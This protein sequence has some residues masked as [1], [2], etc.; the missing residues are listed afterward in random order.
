MLFVCICI[1]CS[2]R[3]FPRRTSQ[4]HFKTGAP[5]MDVQTFLWISSWRCKSAFQ[6]SCRFSYFSY[7]VVW[8]SCPVTLK[9]SHKGSPQARTCCSFGDFALFSLLCFLSLSGTLFIW[10]LHLIA[11]KNE[12]CFLKNQLLFAHTGK[13]R[14]I[15][16]RHAF[17]VANISY[18]CCLCAFLFQRLSFV[19]LLATN[20]RKLFTVHVWF[21]GA[22]WLK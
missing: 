1:C 8:C 16:T 20:F 17:K 19:S 10:L 18:F 2:G 22:V 11:D 9:I 14:F 21:T 3:L 6:L 7:S 12:L 15:L 4:V 5:L 13:H